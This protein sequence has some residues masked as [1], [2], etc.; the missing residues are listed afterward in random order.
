MM[1]QP[2]FIATDYGYV[3]KERGGDGCYRFVARVANGQAQRLADL[4]NQHGE[5]ESSEHPCGRPDCRE[6]HHWRWG[7]VSPYIWYFCPGTS[8]HQTEGSTCT[9]S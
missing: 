5:E 4:L 9:S 1:R 7:Y 3:L 6:S 8:Q 2:A